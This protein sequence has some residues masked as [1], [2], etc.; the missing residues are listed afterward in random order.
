MMAA[1]RWH[2]SIARRWRE[3]PSYIWET[4][5]RWG[6]G[7]FVIREFFLLES[8]GVNQGRSALTC[9]A[10]GACLLPV[11]ACLSAAVAEAGRSRS[12][13]ARREACMRHDMFYM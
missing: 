10:G 5:L 13:D 11:P 12:R 4:V 3:L 9:K 2:A 8:A 7:L 1:S 6:A